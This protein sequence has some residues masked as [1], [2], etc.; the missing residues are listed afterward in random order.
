MNATVE[1]LELIGKQRVVVPDDYQQQTALKCRSRSHALRKCVEIANFDL[2]KEVYMP[3]GIDQGQWSRIWAGTA[4][5]DPDLL[6]PLMDLCGNDVPLR[7][8][9]IQRGYD[10]VR[11]K[12]DLE[13]KV[14][15]LEQEL[16][17]ERRLTLRLASA[18]RT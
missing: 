16:A 5:M 11:V 15:K 7:Y 12:S 10:L 18:L 4:Y 14:A 17:D 3:L 13:A 9:A 1:Q 2:P 8:D 6:F